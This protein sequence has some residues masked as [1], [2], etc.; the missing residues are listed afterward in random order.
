MET[1]VHEYFTVFEDGTAEITEKKSRF[2]AY[3]HSVANEEEALA[4]LDSIRRKHW[5][6]R[7][8]CFAYRVGKR[9]V[10]VRCS[11]DGEQS[12]TAG[13]PILDTLLTYD[14]T[15]TIIIVT[16]YFGGVLLGTGGLV[17]AYTRTASEG[18]LQAVTGVMQLKS[19]LEVTIE[20]SLVGKMKYLF[21][22]EDAAI[23]SEIYEKDAVFKIAVVINNKES[24]LKGITELSA[25]RARVEETDMMYLPKMN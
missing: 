2:I 1:L 17:R 15:N 10:I 16:R 19:I 23:L 11:D 25:A 18:V 6:A 20:Y 4:Y 7:H 12:G 5:D 22:Q 24:L 9:A 13:K 14:L 3:V 8:N 21:A